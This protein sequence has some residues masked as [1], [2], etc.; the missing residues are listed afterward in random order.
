MYMYPVHMHAVI[1]TQTVTAKY[2]LNYIVN[3]VAI[4]CKLEK[5]SLLKNADEVEQLILKSN[6]ILEAFGTDLALG[7]L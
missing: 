4:K 7:S 2:I 6:P 5:R 1:S 3:A